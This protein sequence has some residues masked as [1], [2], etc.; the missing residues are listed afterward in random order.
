MALFS[1]KSVSI[2]EYPI[3]YDSV[4]LVPSG[5]VKNPEFGVVGSERLDCT[6]INAGK[7]SK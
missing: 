7:K 1:N 4:K 6:K 5:E 2:D 3:S